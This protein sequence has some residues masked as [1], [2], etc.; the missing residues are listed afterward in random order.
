M[1]MPAFSTPAGLFSDYS[2]RLNAALEGF[3]WSPVERLAYDLRD[4]WQ[5]RR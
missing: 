5:T 3:D 2:K 1:N 4:C